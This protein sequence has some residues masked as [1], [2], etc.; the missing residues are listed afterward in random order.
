MTAGR[1]RL[2]T[3]PRIRGCTRNIDY[4]TLLPQVY[5]VALVGIWQLQEQLHSYEPFKSLCVYRLRPHVLSDKVLT[6]VY[7]AQE[8]ALLRSHACSPPTESG[9][10]DWG[11]R[12][13]GRA[14]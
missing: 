5:H 4:C 10:I 3:T 6:T 9:R 8:P 1:I 14:V 11:N 7:R 12:Q 13:H 2:I